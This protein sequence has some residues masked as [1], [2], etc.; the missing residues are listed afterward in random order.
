MR[1]TEILL[2][3][4]VGGLGVVGLLAG[5]GRIGGAINI[6]LALDLIRI[7]LGAWLVLAGLRSPEASKRALEVF[8]IVYL[9]FFVIGLFSWNM[10]GLLPSGIGWADQVIHLAGGIL[11]LWMAGAMQSRTRIHRA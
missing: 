10:L 11:A 8:G 4:V 5:E 3:I 6:N 2:G 1:N 7:V 9:A